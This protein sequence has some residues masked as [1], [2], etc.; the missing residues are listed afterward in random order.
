MDKRLPQDVQ[1][2]IDET[3]ARH[4]DN[5]DGEITFSEFKDVLLDLNVIIRDVNDAE[6]KD[7]LSTTYKSRMTS[8]FAKKAIVKIYTGRRRQDSIT[9]SDDGDAESA[10]ECVDLDVMVKEV[11]GCSEDNIGKHKKHNFKKMFKSMRS[12]FD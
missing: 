11:F 4:D 5:M 8:D 7:A 9:D 3:I 12:A 6:I 2:L 10:V 1:R